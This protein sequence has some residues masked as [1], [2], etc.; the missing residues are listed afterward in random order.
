MLQRVAKECAELLIRRQIIQREEQAVYRY[1]FELFWSTAAG[2]ISILLL[3]A[4]FGYVPSALMFIVFFLPIRTFAGG[5][6]A[7]SYEKCFCLTNGIAVVCVI[8]AKELSRHFEPGL[9]SGFLSGLAMVYIW[10]NA[11]VRSV[12]YPQKESVLIKSKKLSRVT[13]CIEIVTLL[14]LMGIGNDELYYTA[15][16]ASYIVAVMMLIANLERRGDHG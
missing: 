16:V 5:Y 13:L 6:H 4:I 9:L 15:V 8:W 14:F 11:P 1:G 7:P 3:S 12:K 2:V 10:I